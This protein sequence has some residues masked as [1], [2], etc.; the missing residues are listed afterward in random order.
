[1]AD[2]TIYDVAI[3]GGGPG[4]YFT[5]LKL[6]EDCPNLKI[7]IFEKGTKRRFGYKNL[8][9]G[10]GGAGTFSDGKLTLSP[11]VGGW[12]GEFI[13]EAELLNL[14][15]Y[16]E[17]TYLKFGFPPERVFGIEPKEKIEELKI[18]TLKSHLT[19]KPYKV[20]HAGTDGIYQVTEN[21]Y[22]HLVGSGVEIRLSTQVKHV[23]Q[24]N[25]G[26]ELELKT[27]EK[28]KASFVVLAPGRAGS[29]WLR[30]EATNL[31]LKFAASEK[32]GV[33][34]G[35]RI[36]T[37]FEI[38]SDFTN[39]L[40]E[41]KIEK[42]TKRF[43]DLVRTFCVC[44]HGQ[45]KIEEKDSLQIINGHSFAN[46]ERWSANTNFA[47]LVRAEFTEPFKNPIGYALGIAE[48]A[49]ELGDGKPLVQRLVDLRD[50]RRSTWD[51]INKKGLQPTLKDVEPGDL[52]Y[53][54]PYRI[55]ANILEFLDNLEL[56]FPGLNDRHTLIYGVETKLYSSRIETR[57]GFETAI[58][59]LF[60]VGDGSGYSRSIA[61]AAVMGVKA[62]Q[63][64]ARR[65]DNNVQLPK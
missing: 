40:H 12:L 48:R 49:N 17:K 45:V 1:M 29:D 11:D 26:F 44:P 6:K 25:D 2:K 18:K 19:L 7:V 5:A 46:P 22:N 38:M 10:F 43:D 36:E 3:V 15:D 53:A 13:G 8:L 61:H 34:V 62:A 27:G 35:V 37:P 60:V 20:R 9:F 50:G 4:G 31:G 16:I 55:L 41:F 58:D 14:L 32:V 63:E 54:I 42:F 57:E 23:A 56:V 59:K 52:S 64:I 65:I 21:I 33:D 30:D 51:K 28:A 47:V 24:T 39:L